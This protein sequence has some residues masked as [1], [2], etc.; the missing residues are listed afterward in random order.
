M[1]LLCF[2]K[3]TLPGGKVRLTACPP[4]FSP[5]SRPLAQKSP[6]HPLSEYFLPLCRK[7]PLRAGHRTAPEGRKRPFFPEAAAR[8]GKKTRLSRAGRS[9]PV[10]ALRAEAQGS[11][12]PPAGTSFP[13]IARSSTKKARVF[14]RFCPL[15]RKVQPPGGPS[16]P[17]HGAPRRPFPKK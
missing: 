14:R 9:P 1:R 12:F 8:A 17:R 13:G 10:S 3:N 5:T 6:R 7:S 11:F 4:P 16:C 2:K 15:R